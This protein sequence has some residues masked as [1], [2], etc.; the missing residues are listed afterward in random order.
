MGSRL[1]YALLLRLAVMVVVVGDGYASDLPMWRFWKT[2]D[3]L[4]EAF[5]RSIS[6]DP[7]GNVLIAHGHNTRMER[8]DGYGVTTLSQPTYPQTVYGTKGGQLWTLTDSGLWHY[9]NDKWSL[10]QVPGVKTAPLAAVPVADGQVLVLTPDTLLEYDADHG[11]ARVVLLAHDTAL[12]HFSDM[13]WAKNGEVWISGQDAFGRFCARSDCSEQWREYRVMMA[14]LHDYSSQSDGDSGETFVTGTRKDGSQVALRI[15]NGNTAVVA[16]SAHGPLMAWAGEEGVIW[17]RDNNDLYRLVNGRKLLVDRDDVL[18]GIVHEV[19]RLPG[20]AFWITTSQGVARYDPPLWRTPP[21][22]AHLQSMVHCIVEDRQGRVWFDFTDRLVRYDGITWK[23][24]PLPDGEQTN[25]YQSN[26][27]FT[28]PDG[29]IVLHALKGHHFFIFDPVRE[30]FQAVDSPAGPSIWAM[31]P[32]RSGGVWMESVDGARH[33]RLHLFDGK[34]F[35]LIT[36]W[37]ESDWRLG[38]LKQIYESKNMGLMLAGTMGLGTFRNGRRGIIPPDRGAAA[39]AAFSVFDEPGGK[40]LVGGGDALREY[41]GTSWKMLANGLGDI[42][43]IIKSN[44]GWTWLTSGTGVHRFKGDTWLANTAEDGL[45]TNISTSVFQ[46]SRGVIWV[47]TTNGLAR[48]FPVADS[49]PPQTSISRDRNVH[50]VAPGGEVKI[51]LSGSD[52]WNYTAPWRLLFSYRLDGG[53]WSHFSTQNYAAFDKLPSG[54]HLLEARAMDRNGNVD[55]TPASFRFS[56]LVA[57]YRHP[58]FLF[59]IGTSMA[60]VAFLMGML[61]SQYRARGRLIAQLNT[62]KDEAEAASRAKSEFLAHMSH[63][64]RTPMNGIMGMTDL[65]LNTDLTAEQQDYLETVRESADHLLVV[66]NDILDF[67][68]IEAGKLELSS[69]EFSL[70]DCVGDALHTVSL[71]AHQKGLEVVCHVLPDVPDVL[72]GDPVRLRQILINLVAN[73]LKFT[74]RGHI[75]VRVSIEN[76]TQDA[77]MLRF[78]VADTGIGIAAEKLQLI[79]APFEQA[80]NSVSRK[81]GGTGLGLAISAKLVAAMHGTIEV[82]SPWPDAASACAGAGSVFQFT[83]LFT[84]CAAAKLQPAAAVPANLGKLAIL[85]ADDNPIN[86]VVLAETLERY[87]ARPHV[88]EDGPGAIDAVARAQASGKPYDLVILD[89]NMPGMDGLTTAERIREKTKYTRIIMLSSAGHSKE[90]A[91]RR[92]IGI[93]AHLMKPVKGQD[94]LRAIGR[95]L[96]ETGGTAARA[97]DAEASGRAPVQQLRILVC[98]DNSINQ[99]LARGVLESQGHEVEIAGD[100]RQA[101]EMLAADHDFDL[102]LMDVQMPHMD[103]FEATAAIRAMEKA[104]PRRRRVPILAMTANAMKGDR[105]RCL[106]AGMDGYVGK[107]ARPKEIFEAIGATLGVQAQT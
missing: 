83:A 34:S 58:G 61:M 98:E 51:A 105:E 54:D 50:E 17:V 31:S 106:S 67:S 89:Y 100:G 9:A 43:T 107:P 21:D 12:G 86:R 48:Y 71:R 77:Q 8:L 22:V 93:E 30:K 42:T 37:Q 16:A 18:S 33:H 5:S 32:S 44:D 4:S 84:V 65:A 59:V 69:V 57:W 75:L 13:R 104:N 91:R 27:I 23:I 101:V 68:R 3:G 97:E 92:N 47:G 85:V 26:S 74:E 39:A 52:K 49:D 15:L 36:E 28:M 7:D 40:V 87:E 90:E 19:L 102:V 2:S 56:V 79:F 29:R 64:I 53:P 95:V 66:I 24:Y 80:D 88:V 82:D 94:L 76:R 41:D 1:P 99:R 25:P 70:R 81:Y 96:A 73:A 10:Q 63:E 55:T 46:D 6:I 78:M 20:G 72:V 38:A 14:G 45:P 60:I 62:A 11:S 35:Q 103:G